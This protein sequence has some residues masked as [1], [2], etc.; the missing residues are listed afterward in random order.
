MGAAMDL[1]QIDLNLLVALDALLDTGSVQDSAKRL[2]V[3]P[4]AL[5]LVSRSCPRLSASSV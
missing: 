2:G 4:S 1:K 3:T 5:C